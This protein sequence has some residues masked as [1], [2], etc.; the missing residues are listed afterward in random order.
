MHDIIYNI[1]YRAGVTSVSYFGCAQ[2]PGTGWVGMGFLPLLLPQALDQHGPWAPQPLPLATARSTRP[3]PLRPG[4]GPCPRRAGGEQGGPEGPGAAGDRSGAR[5]ETSPT[6][7]P[8][9]SSP[10]PSALYPVCGP[11][12]QQSGYPR[13]IVLCWRRKAPFRFR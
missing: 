6:A 1:F 12:T 10:R 9:V 8:G 11:G 4:V 2:A 5:A 13:L 3:Q 7:R